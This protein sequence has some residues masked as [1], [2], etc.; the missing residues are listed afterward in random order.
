MLDPSHFQRYSGPGVYSIHN[1]IS[2]TVVDLANG[3]RPTSGPSIQGYSSGGQAHITNPN[4]LWLITDIG[5]GQVLIINYASGT[6]L[7]AP[8]C[9]TEGHCAAQADQPDKKSVHRKIQTTE[10]NSVLSSKRAG[11]GVRARSL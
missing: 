5:G 3:G 1:A 4:Q 10:A 11:S 9:G 7:S 8:Q 6:F 2:G